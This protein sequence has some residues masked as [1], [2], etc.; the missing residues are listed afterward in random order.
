MAS[1]MR[2]GKLT[3][4]GLTPNVNLHMKSHGIFPAHTVLGFIQTLPSCQ[5]SNSVQLVN[6]LK[7]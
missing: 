2:D 1:G 3:N 4:D 7:L 5:V 6:V